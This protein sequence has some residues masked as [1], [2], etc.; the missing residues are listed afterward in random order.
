MANSKAAFL[1]LISLAIFVSGC[2]SSSDRMALS[3]NINLYDKPEED[4]GKVIYVTKS[5]VV[6]HIDTTKTLKMFR[7]HKLN[8][9]DVLGWFIDGDQR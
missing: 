8:C 3:A 6:C 1:V 5:E 2:E 7:Y 9:G 4:G